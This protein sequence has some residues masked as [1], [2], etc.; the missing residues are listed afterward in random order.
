M[1]RIYDPERGF[2]VDSPLVELVGDGWEEARAIVHL[3]GLGLAEFPVAG[4]TI[5]T[6][7]SAGEDFHGTRWFA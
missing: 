5:V 4:A 1:A 3:P 7:R 6:H 2:D